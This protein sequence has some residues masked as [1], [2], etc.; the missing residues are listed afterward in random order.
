MF[1]FFEGDDMNLNLIN[2][3]IKNKNIQKLKKV[4]DAMLQLFMPVCLYI[5]I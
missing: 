3:L 1:E 2:M 5:H 4:I